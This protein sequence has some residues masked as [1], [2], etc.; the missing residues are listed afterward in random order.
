MMARPSALLRACLACAL[1]AGC[2]AGGTPGRTE[3]TATAVTGAITARDA[4]AVAV[5]TSTKADVAAALGKAT[6]VSF[7]SGFEVWVYRVKRPTDG[8]T[9]N[10]LAGLF[11]AKQTDRATVPAGEFVVLFAPSGV[12]SKTRLRPGGG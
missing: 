2:A 1:T 3:G 5:G 8:Q 7:D 4:G 10:G 9:K 6:V 12:V 11:T